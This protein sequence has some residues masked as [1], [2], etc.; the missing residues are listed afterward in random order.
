ML[1]RSLAAGAWGCVIS[2]AGPTLLA[3]A[4]AAKAAAVGEAMVKAWQ[5]EGVASH[6]QVL[7][8]QLSGSRWEPL[9]DRT[10]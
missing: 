1:F 2:G 9:P 3:L 8:L 5:A 4:P 7:D 6:G 10:R